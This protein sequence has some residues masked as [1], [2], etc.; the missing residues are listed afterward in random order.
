MSAVIAVVMCLFDFVGWKSWP[1]RFEEAKRR[2]LAN[3]LTVFDV[4]VGMGPSARTS[5]AR[6]IQATERNVLWQKERL[7]NLIE[8]G[9]PP[10][11]DKVAFIDADV[12]FDDPHWAEKIEQV[13]D[14][15]VVA[16]PFSECHA[17]RG[18]Q[19]CACKVFSERGHCH[20]APGFSWAARRDWLREIGGVY[21]HNITGGGDAVFALAVL[22]VDWGVM[23]RQLSPAQFM[24]AKAYVRKASPKGKVAWVEGAIRHLNHGTVRSRRYAERNVATIA[25]GY[26]PERDVTIDENGL[27]AW[28]REDVFLQQSLWSYFRKR[29]DDTEQA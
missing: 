27:L 4:E 1:A 21:E 5:A 10:Q 15:A 6:Y 20:G 12:V 19:E 13:L 7:W 2:H 25:A 3:G 28:T 29:D 18:S 11:F 17:G 14:S 22:G 8:S 9:L 23:F 16:Q 26:D 24:H